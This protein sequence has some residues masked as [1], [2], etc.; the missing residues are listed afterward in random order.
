[1]FTA[2]EIGWTDVNQYIQLTAGTQPLFRRILA[3]PLTDVLY[4]L[5]NCRT[6]WIIAG[7]F[8]CGEFK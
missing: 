7:S 5:V 8:G 6:I 2:Q 1:M 4:H 3:R